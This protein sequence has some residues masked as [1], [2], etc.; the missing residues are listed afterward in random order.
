MADSILEAFAA[1]TRRLDQS[2]AL[3]AQTAHPGLAKMESRVEQALASARDDRA[4]LQAQILEG[5]RSGGGQGPADRLRQAPRE[6][7]KIIL[8]AG[9]NGL[10]SRSQRRGGRKLGDLHL[11]PSTDREDLG[12]R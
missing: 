2:Q 7:L 1:L 10:K 11:Q 8:G 5:R 3:A 9:R 12:L 6:G 4:A